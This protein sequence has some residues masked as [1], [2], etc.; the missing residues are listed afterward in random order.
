MF[1][2]DINCTDIGKLH[3]GVNNQSMNYQLID[4]K[5]LG[6]L[7]IS[8]WLSFYWSKAAVKASKYKHIIYIFNW[9]T[10]FIFK[11]LHFITLYHISVPDLVWL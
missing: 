8:Y 1:W 11:L 10:T 4:Y 7:S 3:K 6:R 2:T 5:T 9:S